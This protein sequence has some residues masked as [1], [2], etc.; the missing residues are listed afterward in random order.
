MPILARLKD[1]MNNNMGKSPTDPL[2]SI[3]LVYMNNQWSKLIFYCENG[4]LPIS[5]I[6]AENAIRPFMIERKV[7]LFADT[8]K[9][10]HAS[11]IFYSLIE[12]AKEN[13]IEPY[14]YF[15]HI[16]KA[17]PYTDTV[18]KVEALLP[19]REKNQITA[20]ENTDLNAE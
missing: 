1:W 10:A 8:P 17:L 16:F 7:W 6:L 2:T 4:N 12:T 9:G 11:G 14:A 20:L 5:N 3:A 19:W 18:E 13:E 15:R